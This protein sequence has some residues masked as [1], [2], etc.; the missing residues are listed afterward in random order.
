MATVLV[1]GGAGYIGC[2]LVPRLTGSHRVVALDALWYGR[3]AF[4]EATAGTGAELIEGDIRD[5]ALVDRVLAKH[6]IDAVIHLAAVSNDPCSDLDEALTRSVNYDATERL[7][8]L[9]KRRSVRRFINASSASVYG[10]KQTP[11]VTEDLPLEPLTL[12]ARFKAETEEVLRSL[13]SDAFCGVSVRSATVCGYSPRLRLDLT[14]NILTCHAVTRGQIR[15]FGGSQL[16]PNIHVQDLTDFY[17]TLVDIDPAIVNGRA[18]NVVTSNASVLELAQMVRDEIGPEVPLE[19]VPTDDIRSY[20]LSAEL[21]RR[22]LG[23]CPTR[24]LA[25]AVRELRDAFAAGRVPDPD[26]I[27]YRNV[28]VMKR[29]PERTR[30]AE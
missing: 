24:P 20:H 10:I 27:E 7:M 11:D 6:E 15:V 13:A 29:H 28:E 25:A 8:R 5:D 4:D 26:A 19:I 14:I 30:W 3:A 12:Y 16:R 2:V 23:F 22:E 17:A 1:T 9:A 18:F 21:A